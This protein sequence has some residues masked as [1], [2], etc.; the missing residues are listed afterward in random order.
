MVMRWAA[1]RIPFIH[2]PILLVLNGVQ[3]A[4]VY[5]LVGAAVTQRYQYFSCLHTLENPRLVIGNLVGHDWMR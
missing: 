3:R 1:Y 2:F 5:A 4:L